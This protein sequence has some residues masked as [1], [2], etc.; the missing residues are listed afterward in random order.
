MYMK[1]NKLL[2][3]IL[4]G[5]L[6]VSLLT[7]CGSSTDNT[8]TNTKFEQIDTDLKVG[9]VIGAGTIDDRSFNQGSWE[10]ITQTVANG[11]YITPA[12]ETE[13]DYLV[14]IN[15]LHDAGYEMIFTPGSYFESTI[16]D[17]QSA[18]PDTN[19][20]ILDGTPTNEAGE[21]VI[22][23]NTAAVHFA[24]HE[25]GFIAGVAAAMEINTGEFGFLG[26]MEIPPVVRFEAGFKQGVD[27]ANAQLGTNIT[28]DDLNIVYQGTFSDTAAG[29][30]I[31]A[32]MYDRG[33]DVIFT[34]AG[35][36]GMGAINEA[37]SRAGQGQTAWI[38]GVDSDQY[39]DGIYDASTNASVI[40]TSAVKYIDQAT[41]DMIVNK[42]NGTFPGGEVVT[43]AV[44]NDGV[45]IPAENPNLS[46]ATIE[47]VN[48][49]YQDVKDG[50]ITINPSL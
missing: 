10:G 27:Y 46:E 44:S 33:V 47:K 38:I 37:K 29:Q 25:A 5:M 6:S 15:N 43:Y 21:Q 22:A 7:G 9:M 16:F 24:E 42:V 23:D 8:T 26:G 50:K 14:G 19:F 36:V 11:K 34:A 40:L 3:Q 2:T 41:H 39:M 28:L 30:Q 31:A 18:Y 48:T 17:A 45:G 1:K 35:G 13:S 49:I 12:G 4:C 32:Q 20:V